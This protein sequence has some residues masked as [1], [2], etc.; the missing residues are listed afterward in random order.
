MERLGIKDPETHGVS[1]GGSCAEKQNRDGAGGRGGRKEG[2]GGS[3][4]RVAWKGPPGRQPRRSPRRSRGE[5]GSV[6]A[7]LLPAT[8]RIQRVRQWRV[9][10]TPPRLDGWL[11]AASCL[12]HSHSLCLPGCLELGEC[13]INIWEII[14]KTTLRFNLNGMLYDALWIAHI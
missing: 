11:R 10:P 2:A 14:S 6:H 12:I 4:R 5:A 13:L 1:A 3:C 8:P 9:L 7:H